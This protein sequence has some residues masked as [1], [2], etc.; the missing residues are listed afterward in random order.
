[1]KKSVIGHSSF[2][3]NG[4]RILA[5]ATAASVLF[6]S[7]FMGGSKSA[8]AANSGGA[9]ISKSGV[10]LFSDVTSE[11]T[12][13]SYWTGLLDDADSVLTTSEE[14]EEINA[15]N[16]AASGTNQIDIASYSKTASGET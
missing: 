6:T 9:A 14:V 1:M 13:A 4:K 10:T 5:V 12:S 3:I 7:A 16:I 2:I 11:M 8:L 15:G